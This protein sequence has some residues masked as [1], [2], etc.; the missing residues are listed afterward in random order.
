MLSGVDETVTQMMYARHTY[1][2]Q[3]IFWNYRFVDLVSK[4]DN[5][6][7][8]LDYKHF[9][10]VVPVEVADESQSA[11]SWIGMT[12]I[13]RGLCGCC[14][15]HR[16]TPPRYRPDDASGSIAH[17]IGRIFGNFSGGLF[18]D[19]DCFGDRFFYASGGHF[20][21]LGYYPMW[22]AG[23]KSM[24]LRAYRRSGFIRQNS[25]SS[26]N[27]IRAIVQI[28]Q[29]WP[30]DAGMRLLP[31]TVAFQRIGGTL[32]A[33]TAIAILLGW[34]VELQLWLAPWFPKLPL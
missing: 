8:F 14:C 3:D 6:D 26:G 4:A 2:S 20:R 27:G 5:G 33:G 34:D 21:C 1:A 7:R 15:P 19:R 12:S 25:P 22:S 13:D 30:S 32:M 24:Q 28:S 9:N 23:I 18:I 29:A 16:H 31:Y 10:S 11:A 17:W